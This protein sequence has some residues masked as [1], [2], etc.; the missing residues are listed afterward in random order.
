M[1][2][3]PSIKEGQRLRPSNPTGFQSTGKARRAGDAISGVGRAV[4]SVGTQMMAHEAKLRSVRRRNAMDAAE[5]RY[6]K[7]YQKIFTEIERTGDGVDD[8]KKF[9]TEAKKIRSAKIP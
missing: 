3:V 7:E 6:T 5:N 8:I 4:A 1:P 2:K 9:E